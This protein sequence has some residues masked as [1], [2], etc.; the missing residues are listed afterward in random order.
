M[1]EEISEELKSEIARHVM[2]PDNYG[3]LDGANGVGIA[4]DQATNSYVVMYLKRDENHIVDIKFGTNAMSQDVP[5][6]G[7]IFTDMIKGDD[8]ASAILTTEGLEKELEQNYAS[9]PKPKID[10]SKPEGQQVEQIS[11]E[12]QDSANMVLTSFRAAMRHYE[13]AVEGIEEE[14]FEMNIAKTCP[15]SLGDCHFMLPEKEEQN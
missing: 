9:L 4:M 13:R 14:Y 10:T 15:Y 2:Q 7:S 3:K 5:T 1:Q 12:H 8:I 6:L 11:T